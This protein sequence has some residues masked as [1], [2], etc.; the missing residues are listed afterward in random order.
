MNNFCID[1]HCH[2]D[3]PEFDTDREQV[4]ERAK[5]AGVEYLINIGSSLAGT[6]KSLELAQRYAHIYATAGI[7]PHHAQGIAPADLE[8]FKKL[9]G[10]RKVV[11]IGEVGLDFYKNFSP[12][13]AQRK[14]FNDLLQISL[15]RKLP[16]I[17]HNRLA[18]NEILDI[19]ID[20]LGKSIRGVIHCFS[21][22]ELFL[23]K[24]LDLGFYISFTANI[25]Y[26]KADDLRQLVKITPVENMLL[27][28]DAPFLPP[29]SYRG[30]RNEPAY[31]KHLIEEISRLKG[32]SGEDIMRITTY[33]AKTLF[34]LEEIK[35]PEG[36]IA[37]PIRNSLYLNITNRCTDNCSFCLRHFTEWV[38]GHNLKLDPEPSLEEV[39]K[40]IDNYSHR[41]FKEI[42]F[43]GYGE[44]LLRLDLILNVSRYLKQKGFYVRINT[45]G[46]GNLIHKKSIVSYLV[47]L[48]DEVCVSL[49]VDSGEKYYQIC[50]PQF[51]ENTF[52]EV[53]KFV[54][55]CK[56][57]LPKVSVT[58]LNL[59]QVDLKNCQQIAQ[60]LGVDF[61]IREYNVVG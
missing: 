22:D 8:L 27:E 43:C 58:F 39:I 26:Q 18:N 54:L 30:K 13:Q 10:E 11:A 25:T 3:F 19:I 50:R 7:H 52:E 53:K 51:G 33:N 49:N 40:A 9:S 2:L 1:T 41:K 4:I 20:I 24:C 55:E 23:K 35:M 48:V 5:K 28:T 32:L 29:Q 6:K 59:P 38:K 37:Y 45:N 46:T 17:I 34:S 15:E 57:A 31:L 42:V 16:V 44:P 21:G 14:I 56:K 36:V 60:Q 12:P 47:N 61:R